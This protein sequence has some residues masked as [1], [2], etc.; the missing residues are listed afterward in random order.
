[1]REAEDAKGTYAVRASLPQQGYLCVDLTDFHR[2]LV[3]ELT[4]QAIENK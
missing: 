3:P 1:M 2:A 4:S